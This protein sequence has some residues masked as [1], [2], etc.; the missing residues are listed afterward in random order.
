[1]TRSNVY[2]D[3][4]EQPAIA[5]TATAEG[6]AVTRTERLASL[7]STHGDRLYRLARRLSPT[8]D[9]ARDLVQ[10]TFLRAASRLR[11]VP[12]G[13][14]DEEAW[15]TRVLVNIRRDQWR[16]SAIRRRYSNGIAGGQTLSQK[17]DCES[18]LIARETIWCALDCL[19]PR[20]R[21]VVIMYELEGL[22]IP[23]IAALLG[24]TVITA[25]WHLSRG[26]R[27]LAKVLKTE[28]GEDQ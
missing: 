11:S 23:A 7:F 13:A 8:A 28:S 18:A 27:D 10:E 19:P 20:R 24:I 22:A 1:M 3:M 2:R 26:R 6:V 15:L 16:K 25:R 5:V 9:E 14:A 17:S 12:S 4:R 21:A